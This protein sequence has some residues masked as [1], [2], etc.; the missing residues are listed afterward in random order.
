[1]SWRGKDSE[2]NARQ[3]SWQGSFALPFWFLLF[4]YNLVKYILFFNAI[5]IVYY[6][7]YVGCVRY[8]CR[9]EKGVENIEKDA[10]LVVFLLNDL[11]AT[12]DPRR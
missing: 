1:M 12:I 8:G 11:G 6:T 3:K 5:I 9:T 2:Y 10:L 4:V 7:G